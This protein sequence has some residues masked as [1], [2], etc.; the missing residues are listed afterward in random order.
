MAFIKKISDYYARKNRRTTKYE[1]RKT[2]LQGRTFFNIWKLKKLKKI[3][4]GLRLGR[5]TFMITFNNWGE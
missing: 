5:N 4:I 2:W 3:E 1:T